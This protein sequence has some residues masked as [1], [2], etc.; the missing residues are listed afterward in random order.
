MLRPP[1]PGG[2]ILFEVGATACPANRPTVSLWQT[3][4]NKMLPGD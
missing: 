2:R 4:F 1:P 3:A